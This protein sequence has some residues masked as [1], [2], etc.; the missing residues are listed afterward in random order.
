MLY[1]VWPILGFAAASRRLHECFDD[2][3]QVSGPVRSTEDL[4][5]DA[6]IFELDLA[7]VFPASTFLSLG[8]FLSSTSLSVSS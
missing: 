4:A 6:E 1:V 7:L 3:D 5:P 2:E 8:P